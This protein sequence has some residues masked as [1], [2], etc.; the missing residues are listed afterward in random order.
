MTQIWQIVTPLGTFFASEFLL[1]RAGEGVPQ[2][3]LAFPWG[4]VNNY[5]GNALGCEATRST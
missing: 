2:Q 3:K 4:Y 1:L 5:K